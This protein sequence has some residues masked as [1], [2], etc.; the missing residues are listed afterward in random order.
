MWFKNFKP[1]KVLSDRK[2]TVPVWLYNIFISYVIFSADNHV[3][4]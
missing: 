4:Y 1:V 3:I 2:Y